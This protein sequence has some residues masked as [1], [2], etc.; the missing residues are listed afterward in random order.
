[1]E[2]ADRIDNRGFLSAELEKYRDVYRSTH[3]DLF[4]VCEQKSDSVTTRLFQANLSKLEDANETHV[5][6]AIGLWLRCVR[7]CQASLLLLERGLVP[8]AQA[9]IRSAYEF[10]FYAVA[11]LKDP[12]ILDS[13]WEGDGYARR[14]QAESMLREGREVGALNEEQ[15]E[16]LT[17]LIAQLEKGKKQI[18][19]YDAAKKAGMAYLYATVYRGM[20]FV[21][22]HA[23]LAAT[24]LMFEPTGE[25][26]SA[27]FGPSDADLPFSVGLVD[28]CL[29]EGAEHFDSLLHG[30]D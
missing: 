29:A 4:A 5:V 2:E 10:L 19:S 8:E 17:S 23:T 12:K 25:H 21:G 28:K 6:V 15:T 14:E 1:M 11:I 16:R 24:N 18:S 26:V 13:M 22:A 3:K 20:S 9:L 30:A 7:S 27:V